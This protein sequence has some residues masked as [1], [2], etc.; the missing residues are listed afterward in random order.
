VPDSAGAGYSADAFAPGGDL[1]RYRYLGDR[2]TD[3]RLRGQA[4]DP[5]RRPDGRCIVGRS[6]QLVRFGDGRARVVNRRRLRL[7][8]TDP[9]SPLATRRRTGTL[10]AE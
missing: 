7:V 10:P 1:S 4:C 6:K 8:R 5:V 9:P 2:W 3:P